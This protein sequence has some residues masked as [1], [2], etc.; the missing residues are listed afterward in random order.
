MFGIANQ[1]LAS[2]ALAVGTTVI[3]NAGRARYAWVTLAPL[4]FVA[5]TTL[6][7]GYLSITEKFLPIAAA[8][9]ALQGYL[10]AALIAIM[11]CAVVVVLAESARRW[12][13]VSSG[14]LAAG[15]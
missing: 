11:M 6:T 3:V 13:R 7:A 15:A 14:Q 8:G 10:N 4:C 9:K 12:Y 2:T 1:L 5:T